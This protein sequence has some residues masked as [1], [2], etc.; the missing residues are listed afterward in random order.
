MEGNVVI[1][2]V[3]QL[4]VGTVIA[5]IAGIVAIVVAL[6]LLG[7]KVYKLIEKYRKGRNAIDDKMSAFERLKHNDEQMQ[8]SIDALTEAMQQ[9]L[10]DRLNQRIRE[11]YALKYIPEQEFENF[12]HLYIAYKDVN[13]NGEMEMRFHKCIDDLHVKAKTQD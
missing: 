1:E 6:T 12:Q 8:K 3:S 9:M 7:V 5:W 2:S 4:P 11:Y 10:A 13:G